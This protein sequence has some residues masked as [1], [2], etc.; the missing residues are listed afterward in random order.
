MCDVTL[1]N[2]EKLYPIIIEQIEASCFLAFDTEFSALNTNDY[3]SST[4]TTK[5]LYEK[6]R[7]LVTNISIFQFGLA[8]FSK[9]I[10]SSDQNYQV[11][12]YNFY[13][14]PASIEPIDV[15]YMMQASST[16]F[17][18]QN[19]FDF[20][21][22]FYTGISFLNQT[23]ENLLY[24]KFGVKRNND[25]QTISNPEK[26]N[27]QQLT[28]D[29]SPM[30][31]TIKP[32]EQTSKLV[33]NMND[34][35]QQ[36]YHRFSITEK[37]L[38][39]KLCT[40]I[41]D[42]LIKA[43]IGDIFY[44]DL[45]ELSAM[46]I[47]DYL[48]H[49][50]LRRVFHTIWTKTLVV[51]VDDSSNKKKILLIEHITKEEYD[52][53]IKDQV[54]NSDS[55]TEDNF[56]SFMKPLIGFT[57][58]IRYLKD[59]YR[60]PLVGHNIM[61][62]MLIIC[63]K[64]IDHLPSKLE[65]FQNDVTNCFPFL[66]D[67]K[68]IAYEMKDYL[69]NRRNHRT[70]T[71]STCSLPFRINASSEENYD[72]P[73]QQ[74][75]QVQENLSNYVE[76]FTTNTALSS[77]YDLLTSKFYDNQIFYKPKID[78]ASD[79]CGGQRY[80]NEKWKHEAGYDAYMAGCIFVKLIYFYKQKKLAESTNYNQIKKTAN[81]YS[82]I[83]EQP[84][85]TFELCL[86][87][88]KIFKN[89]IHLV[90]SSS[91]IPCLCVN[92]NDIYSTNSNKSLYQSSSYCL[93]VKR[94]TKNSLSMKLDMNDIVPRFSSYCPMKF[95]LNSNSTRVYLTFKSQNCLRIILNDYDDHH[96]Y[97]IEKYS[98]FKHSIVIQCTAAVTASV[99]LTIALSATYYYLYR[100]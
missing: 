83:S 21:K 42:W 13:L 91:N 10:S 71:S 66:F 62:D 64:F 58:I 35:E 31:T 6:R 52:Q 17:L 86:Y 98:P 92:K 1:E 39:N 30:K 60:K 32:V 29:Q 80:K 97:Q 65:Q 40:I 50:E 67:T 28:E 73:L 100:K 84:H 99:A 14:N 49:N 27:Q 78:F 70:T 47:D 34:T 19:K 43:R 18:T 76:N 36:Q 63:D 16:K 22:C 48:L 61:Y 23:Q 56:E 4:Q 54:I 41:N 15:T 37:H 69:F 20:N 82:K 88:M 2:F 59:N 8:I 26:E 33:N 77:L 87:E 74:Q 94:K 81:F 3:T 51:D 24:K 68:Y 96:L 75:Q 89:R 90:T 85:L 55:N 44:Y 12:I 11:H 7:K 93:V 46:T 25:D 5:K 95:D 79:E 57:K 53:R 72:D 38:I 45:N 9:S